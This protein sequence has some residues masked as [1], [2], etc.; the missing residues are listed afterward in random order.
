[1]N[2]VAVSLSVS[3]EEKGLKP[4]K[5]EGY[6]AFSEWMASSDDFML[7]RRFGQLNARVLLLL[8]DRIVQMEEKL[9]KIDT[10]AQKLDDTVGRCD[11]LRCDPLEKRQ[12]SL[13]ELIPVL[14]S[15]SLS[16]S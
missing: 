15:Y 13:D 12:N 11:S 16:S 3:E 7:F 4:W 6:P 9:S 1:M 8:Q 10:D 2:K 5:Y 14:K